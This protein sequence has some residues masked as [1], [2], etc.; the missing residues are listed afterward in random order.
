MFVVRA[1]ESRADS[2]GELVGTQQCVGLNHLAF[3][4]DPLGLHRIE[5]RTLLGQQASGDPHSG[6]TA[7]VFDLPVALP[8][9]APDLRSEEHTS[10]L[11]SRQYLVCRLLLEKI[12]RYSL[13]Q[14]SYRLTI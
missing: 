12:Y 8:D 11:Q 1:V 3:A 4:M 10:E 14:P 2:L 5:P 7:A 13:W 9:P 6:F